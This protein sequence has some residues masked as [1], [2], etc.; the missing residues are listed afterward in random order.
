MAILTTPASAATVNTLVTKV[1]RALNDTDTDTDNQRWSTAD[2]LD[3]LDDQ[4]KQM[5]AEWTS[6]D[7]AAFVQLTSMTYGSGLDSVALPA[8]VLAQ[9]IYKIVNTTTGENVFVPHRGLLETDTYTDESGW[10]F[11]GNAVALRPVPESDQTLVLYTLTPYVP[12]AQ[13]YPATSDTAQHPI[14]VNYEELLIL[15]AAIRLQENDI[16]IPPTR[17]GRFAMLW[18]QFQKNAARFKG[19]SYVKN[20]R[21]LR[22]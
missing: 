12:I 21:K 7:P 6:Q 17:I 9:G 16:E 10:S 2:I 1:R 8:A 14:P 22:N 13:S 11:I 20:T 5:F 19:R 4:L 18:D 3:A 15:G